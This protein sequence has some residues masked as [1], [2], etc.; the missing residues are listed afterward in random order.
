MDGL[1]AQQS[2]GDWAR[3]PAVENVNEKNSEA[4]LALLQAKVAKLQ[5]QV[6]QMNG[7]TDNSNCGGE[8]IEGRQIPGTLEL[9]SGGITSDTIDWLARA[10]VEVSKEEVDRW[11]VAR[12]NEAIQWAACVYRS[13]GKD[14][15]PKPDFLTEITIVIDGEPYTAVPDIVNADTIRAFAGALSTAPV[16]MRR[17]LHDGEIFKLWQGM[18]FEIDRPST[19][20]SIAEPKSVYING[21]RYAVV[22]SA[23]T[24]RRIKEISASAYLGDLLYHVTKN[25][26]GELVNLLVEDT[27]M[28]TIESGMQFET[29][30]AAG[31]L[32]LMDAAQNL[33]DILRRRNGLHRDEARGIEQL[34]A[35]MAPF[36]ADAAE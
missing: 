15:P 33:I 29:V 34:Q 1:E 19:P 9:R 28:V 4:D 11:T 18:T 14:T 17:K 21:G 7:S 20:A 30:S 32:T 27:D 10:G 24:G 3:R 22:E 23:L 16:Y 2:C 25:A 36:Q 5:A 26:G 12:A 13:G 8:L 31:K 6:D 35:A